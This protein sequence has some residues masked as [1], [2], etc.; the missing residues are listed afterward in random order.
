MNDNRDP[1]PEKA[2]DA[3][4]TVPERD[5]HAAARGRARFLAEAADLAPVSAR[6][7][8]RQRGWN[9]L[10]RKERFAMNVLVSILV[11]TALL[12][13]GGAAT[14][15]AAQNDLPGQALYPVKIFSED[16]RLY[17]TS[18]P[19]EEV[20]LLMQLVQTRVGEM[21]A[22]AAQGGIVPGDVQLRLEQHIEQALQTAAGMDDA[23]MAGAL[24]QIRTTLQ[25]QTQTMLQAQSSGEA[26]Q[27]MTQ[28]REMLEERLRLVDSGFADPQ[29]FRNTVRQEEE[30]R[31][32]QTETPTPG[33]G[34]GQGEPQPSVTPGPHGTPTGEPGGPNQPDQ[35]P[36]PGGG[37]GQGS[38]EG[39]GSG[40]GG[41][42]GPQPTPGGQGG[43]GGN[44]P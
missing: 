20:D 4:R 41:G 16:A 22:L 13:G 34:N 1:K 27:I 3:L 26:D 38:G 40:S 39:T 6:Q 14:V 42:P 2:L 28:T 25:T 35:T 32:G 18:N 44:H 11:A 33:T 10:T 8:R 31:S 23:N 36:G 15:Q 19:Q 7:R 17:F 5:P 30:N 9:P 12:L 21:T 37:S 43:Q 24:L 29:G